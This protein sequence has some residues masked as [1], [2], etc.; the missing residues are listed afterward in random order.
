MS[1]DG[2]YIPVYQQ[3]ISEM[4]GDVSG[5]ILNIMESFTESGLAGVP[6]TAFHPIVRC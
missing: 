3:R 1:G 2:R 5:E 4:S 6:F